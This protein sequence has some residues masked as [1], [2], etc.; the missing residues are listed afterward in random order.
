MAIIKLSAIERRRVSVFF[1]CLFLAIVAW[2]AVTLSRTYNFKVKQVLAYKNVPK[3][4]AFHSLQSDTVS[5]TVKGTGWQMLFSKMNNMG[6]AIKVDLRS[7]EY[8]DYVLLSE[9]IKAINRT[10]EFEHEIVSFNPDTLYFDFS[11]RRVKRVPI[12]LAMS[13]KY[14]KQFSQSDD[15]IIN[16]RY[17][18]ISGPSNVIDRITYWKTDSLKAENVS[19]GIDTRIKL[20]PVKEG[21]IGLYPNSVQVKVPVSEFTEKTVEVPVTLVNNSNYYSVNILPKKVKV[22]FTTALNKYTETSEEF[23]EVCADLNIWKRYGYKVLP[24]KVTKLPDFCRI[25]KIEPQNVDFIIKK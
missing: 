24:V 3:K 5:V 1:T 9:Q 2:L 14:R 20:A 12:Q 7:L 15:I 22:T 6:P 10:K 23:F 8:E 21:N 13:L 16:P 25:V 4:R 17:V 11:H 18:T 19:E